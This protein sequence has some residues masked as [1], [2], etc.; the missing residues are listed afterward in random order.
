MGQDGSGAEPRPTLSERER[1]I[2]VAVRYC[3]AID[4]RDWELLRR[5]FVADPV[6]SY[7]GFDELRGFA[8]LAEFLDGILSPLDATQHIVTNFVV[9]ID[10]E[11][12]TS[13]CYLHAQHVRQAAP[14]GALFVVAGSYRDSLVRRDGE[15][16]IGR[17]DYT[18][19]WVDGNSAVLG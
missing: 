4:T 17:R 12:A 15:W 11:E 5:C 16:L 9:A 6:V 18:T 7:E 10:G 1:V 19:T 3:T 2:E 8:A 14:G 13:T